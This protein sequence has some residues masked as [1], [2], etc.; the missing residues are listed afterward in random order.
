MLKIGLIVN[1]IC[2]M[3]G[4]VGLKGTDG[5]KI[6]EKARDLGAV[7]QAPQ[8]TNLFLEHLKPIMSQICFITPPGIMGEDHIKTLGFKSKIIEKSFFAH[9]LKIF[10]TSAQDSTIAAKRLLEENV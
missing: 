3:G 10:K 7:P 2:G 8:R 4:I 6:L 5:E 9:D 1:P